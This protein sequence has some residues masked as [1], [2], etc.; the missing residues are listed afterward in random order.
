[1]L[2]CIQVDFR[3]WQKPR[4][5]KHTNLQDAELEVAL[6]CISF[7]SEFSLHGA[8]RVVLLKLFELSAL[9]RNRPADLVT[10]LTAGSNS[11]SW[12]MPSSGMGCHVA[13]LGTDVSEERIASFIMVKISKLRKLAVTSNWSKQRASVTSYFW[14]C[15]K[16]GNSFHPDDGGDTFLR[17]VGT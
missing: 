11:H 15:S 17:N 12:R 10:T 9:Q 1:M 2:R 3:D 5:K 8:T 4:I 7:Y 16:L 6:P 13:L 14:R